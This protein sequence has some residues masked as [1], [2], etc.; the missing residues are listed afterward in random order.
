MHKLH[1]MCVC[2]GTMCKGTCIGND[3]VIYSISDIVYSHI[4]HYTIVQCHHI[5]FIH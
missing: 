5:L 4:G 2:K 3:D 1:C